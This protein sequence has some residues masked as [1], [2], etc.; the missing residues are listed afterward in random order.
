LGTSYSEDLVARGLNEASIVDGTIVMVRRLCC[1]PNPEKSGPLY[2]Y[3]P[4]AIEV[5]PGDF[6]E[7]RIGDG[8]EGTLASL[9][10][11]TRLLQ[12]ADEI[13]GKCRWDPPDPR[14]WMRYVA[15][16]WMPAEGWVRQDAK[17][18]PAW[19]KPAGP[20]GVR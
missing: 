17:L 8:K 14:L 16:E 13:A 2:L 6:I 3:N 18:N 1:H 19:Y 20:V 4:L 11:V 10:T 7:F 5:A 12:R 9:I 15:C